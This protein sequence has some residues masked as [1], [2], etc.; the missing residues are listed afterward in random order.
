MYCCTLRRRCA[1]VALLLVFFLS[2]NS[3]RA[4][5]RYYVVVFAYDSNPPTARGAHTFATFL[6]VGDAKDGEKAKP[7]EAVTISWLPASLDVKLLAPPERGNNFDLLSTMK[8]AQTQKAVIAA[9]G[10]FETKKDLFDR[11][12]A[13]AKKL[14]SK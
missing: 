8:I 9:W 13:Q 4:A 14:S 10:P 7:V 6:K 1:F 3:A 12:V 5:D 2:P 11:A